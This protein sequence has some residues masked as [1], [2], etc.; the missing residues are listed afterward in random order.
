MKYIDFFEKQCQ[1]VKIVFIM[2]LQT[3]N[4]SILTA[5]MSSITRRLN[6]G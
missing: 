2:K 6:N 4:S 1:L 5:P 3:K